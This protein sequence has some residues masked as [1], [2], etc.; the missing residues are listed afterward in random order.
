MTRRQRVELIL[1]LAVLV[2]VAAAQ[3]AS[4][5]HMVAAYSWANS[6]GMAIVMAIVAVTTSGALVA[7]TVLTPPG[8][9]RVALQVGLGLLIF[10]EV[11]GNFTAGGLR[12]ESVMPIQAGALFGLSGPASVRLAAILFSAAIPILV[13]LQLYA[14]T[15]IAERLLDEPAENPIAWKVMQRHREAA[16]D[17]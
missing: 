15:E 11:V 3:I 14:A 7:L 16:N 2:F 8:K 10:T 13:W 12:A 17:Q 9:A 5:I 6:P 1:F 4:C